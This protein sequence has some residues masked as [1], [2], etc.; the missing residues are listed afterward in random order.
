M[1]DLVENN[2]YMDYIYDKSLNNFSKYVPFSEYI[3]HCNK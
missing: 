3:L 1:V 2:L